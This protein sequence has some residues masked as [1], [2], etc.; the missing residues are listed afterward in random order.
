L[1]RWGVVFK[2]AEDIFVEE[3]EL[4]FGVEDGEEGWGC[5]GGE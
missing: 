5:D 4:C 1:V 3:E 2:C